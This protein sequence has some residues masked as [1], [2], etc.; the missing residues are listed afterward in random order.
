[1][2]RVIANPSADESALSRVYVWLLSL[3]NDD[4]HA[5]PADHQSAE[6]QMPRSEIEAMDFT[7]APASISR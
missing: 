2:S 4:I 5:Q 7:A 3:V 1:M 6:L